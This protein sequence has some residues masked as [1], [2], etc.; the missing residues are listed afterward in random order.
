VAEAVLN[1]M[2]ER[3][4][5]FRR[6]VAISAAGHVLLVIVSLV[7]PFPR[8]RST[9]MPGVVSVSLVAAPPTAAAKPAAKPA[10]AKPKPKPPEAKPPPPKPPEVKTDKTLLPKE[11]TKPPKK[12]P[13]KPKTVTPPPKPEEKLDYT[14][15]IDELREELG[16]DTPADQPDPDL[17]A[18]VRPTQSGPPGHGPGDPLDPEVADWVRRVKLHVR[19]NWIL[20]PSLKRRIIQAEVTIELDATGNVLEATVT[21][22]SGD[23]GF[24]QSVLRAID[25][26]SPLPP[27]PDSGEWP[28]LFSPQD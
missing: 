20:D 21:N 27:P 23:G 13:P 15:A 1:P 10:A 7:S 14:D 6:A 25:K 5:V 28:L 18:S 2:E 16:E 12:E 4:R 19:K 8:S 22:R 11:A 24:D 9:V 17:I 26:S 3:E